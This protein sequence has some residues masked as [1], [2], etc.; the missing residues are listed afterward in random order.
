[1]LAEH[2]AHAER[3]T[4]MAHQLELTEPGLRAVARW[5]QLAPEDQRPFWFSG[6]FETR[7]GRLDRATGAFG[8]C[9]E[10]LGDT[11]AGLTLVLEALAAE[12]TTDAATAIMS[13][14]TERFPGT[15]AGHYGLARL[16]MRSGDFPL[17]L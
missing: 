3:A 4:R 14:L 13:R 11:P 10:R 16:A 17:A 7:A 12:P 8:E 15:A 6:V 2:P 1:L 5:R 9:I